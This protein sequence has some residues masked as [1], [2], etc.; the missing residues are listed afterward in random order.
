M[1]YRQFELI[2][3]KMEKRYGKIQKGKEDASA[4]TLFPM[5]SNL[6]KIYRKYPEANSD[7]LHE[8]ICL[9]L[10]K[11]EDYLQGKETDLS[12]FETPENIRLRDALLMSFDPFTNNGIREILCEEYGMNLEDG[13]SFEEYL[14]EPVMCVIRI[15]DSL[16]HWEKRMGRNGYFLFLDNW[17]GDKVSRDDEMHYAIMV[18]H[19]ITGDFLT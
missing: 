2:I 4:M 10:H 16:E 8:A 6:L 7:R 13:K 17:M 5:E 1:D 11:L 3:R 9:A 15:Q 12:K 14:R 18:K 19:P